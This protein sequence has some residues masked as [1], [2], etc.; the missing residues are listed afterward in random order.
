MRA[1]GKEARELRLDLRGSVGLRDT[2]RVEA[3]LARCGDERGL[4]RPR[5]AQKSRS[6]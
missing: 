5:I 6:A 1:F 4:D 3:V 2:D